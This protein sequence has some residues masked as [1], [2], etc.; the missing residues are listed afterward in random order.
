M[1]SKFLYGNNELDKITN[2]SLKGDTYTVFRHEEES[3]EVPVEYWTIY[4]HEYKLGMTTLKG[5]LPFRYAEKYESRQVQYLA[6]REARQSG[7][8][9]YRVYHPAESLMVKQGYTYFKGLEPSDVSI[10]SFDIETTGLTHDESSLVVL[11]SNTFRKDGKVMRKLFKYSDYETNEEMINAWCRW[12]RKMDP[13]FLAGH[14]IFG[15]DLPYLYYCS[16]VFGLQLGRDGSKAKFAKNPRQFRKDASQF[17]DYRDVSVFGRELID[18]FFLSIKYDVAGNYESYGLKSIMQQEGLVREDRQYYDA[19]SI[20]DT[21]Q[22]P[23]EFEKICTYAEHDADDALALYDLMIAPYFY[24]LQSIPK[25]LQQVINSGRSTGSQINAFLVRSYLQEGHS[26]PKASETHHYAGGISYG[27]PGLYRHVNKVDVA[28]LYPSI[29]REYKIYSRQKDPKANFLEMVEAFTDERLSNKKLA[30]ETG[31][32]KYRDLEQAQKII[33]NSAY[34]FM[35]CPGLNFNSPDHAAEV[36]GYGREILER[37]VKWAKAREY[38]I[39]NVDTDSFSYTTGKKLSPEEFTTEID[40]L[41]TNFPD[42]IRWEN[43]GQYDKALIVKAKNYVLVDPKRIVI[44]GNSLKAPMKEPAL[45]EFMGE[46]IEKLLMNR[47]DELYDLYNNYANTIYNFNSGS[48]VSD[49]C[50]KKTITKAVLNPERTNEARI[51]E[52]AQ[53]SGRLLQEGDK[54]YVYFRQ[55]DQLSLRENFDG[56]ICKKKLYGKLFNTLKTFENVLD[57]G[58]FPNYALKRNEGRMVQ[59]IVGKEI[60]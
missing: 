23:V 15:F 43:D 8:N 32:R 47:K 1:N 19:A 39:V 48:D 16:G 7:A 11:I 53:R 3:V 13:T 44:K 56:V 9:S 42:M 33:I 35:G 6:E 26:L 38:A 10:L 5:D 18:T 51:K 30:N 34:G 52:A 41:N 46:V 4:D 49:W 60:W 20:R 22:D 31:E 54:I 25:T 45:R 29:I 17:Y 57:V 2:I 58:V 36:T 40:D 55:E 50:S 12:I 37:G 14:N 21:Y 24:S 27:N 28:S 59:Y